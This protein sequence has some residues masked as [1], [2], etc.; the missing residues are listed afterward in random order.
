M[1][2]R[3]KELINNRIK[4]LIDELIDYKKGILNGNCPYKIYK[5]N[6]YYECKANCRSCTYRFFE[7]M[8]KQ[9]EEENLI[10]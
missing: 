6:D 4:N 2:E 8:R 10:D 9:Y 3:L 7:E 5:K 1:D